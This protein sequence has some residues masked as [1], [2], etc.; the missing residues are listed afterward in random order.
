ME[1]SIEHYD[2]ANNL[3]I[4]NHTQPQDITVTNNLISQVQF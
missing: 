2:A 3:S 4:D 1:N